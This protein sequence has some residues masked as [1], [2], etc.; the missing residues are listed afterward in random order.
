[1]PPP[2]RPLYTDLPPPCLTIAYGKRRPAACLPT[3]L[4]TLTCPRLSQRPASP[5]LSFFSSG[6]SA[7]V[8]A[9]PCPLPVCPCQGYMPIHMIPNLP[10]IVCTLNTPRPLP[11]VRSFHF[12]RG[13]TPFK[14]HF[15]FP[16]VFPLAA[17]AIL[18]PVTQVFNQPTGGTSPMKN[19]FLVLKKIPKI[20]LHFW[21]SVSNIIR[22][23]VFFCVHLRHGGSN[24]SWQR[25]DN[26]FL[27]L[28][29]KLVFTWVFPEGFP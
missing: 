10:S 14:T 3:C 25:G 20:E 4:P 9:L 2:P 26:L 22:L 19:H 6:H 27:I 24:W 13:L 29:L 11:L 23:M 8:P 18:L 28:T 17:T 16:A 1:M 7:A 5:R 15:Y 12:K 21:P